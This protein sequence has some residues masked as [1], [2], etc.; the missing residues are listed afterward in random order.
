MKTAS[1]SEIDA[2]RIVDQLYDI[3]LDP[4]TLDTFIGA[5]NDAGLDADAARKTIKSID[6]FDQAYVAH[7]ER[8]DTFL[9][10]G[11]DADKGPDLADIM[12]PFDSLAAFIVDQH[13]VVV[14]S[15]EGAREAFHMTDGIALAAL[16]WP[17]HVMED[18]EENLGDLF[19]NTGR[20]DL[21]L[22]LDTPG[23]RGPALFQIRLLPDAAPSS[24]R[25]A[26][27]VTTQYHWKAALGQ[28]L[29]EVFDLTS[30]EQ[31]VVRALVEGLDAKAIAM[32]RGT[33]EGT[34]R[35]QIKSILSKMNARSQSEVIRL[36]LSLRDVAQPVAGDNAAGRKIPLKRPH[37]DWL[38]SEAYKPLKS[39][40]LPDG[41]KMDYHDMGLANGAPVLFSHMGYGL[42]RWHEP[43]LR[44]AIKNG[45]RVIVPIRA[46]YGKS[47][48]LS[49]DADVLAVCRSDTRH[50][51]E[52]LG[53]AR[54]P[55]VPQ[56]NDL[57]FA[58]D[59]A[60]HHPEMV[61][62]IIGICARPF[63]QGDRH[64]AGMAKW[65]RFFLSTARHAPHLLRFTAKA[66]VALSKRIGPAEMFR[67][68]NQSSVSDMAVL[69]DPEI[70]SILLA[71]AD[72]IAGK[73]TDVSQAYAM[74]LLETEADWSHLIIRAK[75][76]PTSFINGNDDP[77]TDVATIAEYRETY[78][79][80]EVEVI[81][82][83]GQMLIYKH[84]DMVIPKLAEAAKRATASNGEG[85]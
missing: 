40:T 7:L 50:L 53:I 46:G 75:N 4:N 16:P 26:L 8:A 82:D 55:F 81:Q 71:N 33:S 59:M 35:S 12:A 36:V 56:G 2:D 5:W 38:N 66:A 52:H 34:V 9:S 74:E 6:A 39:I 73:D 61:S 15:N 11:S 79:W 72:L 48:P 43:M 10:R 51:L 54:L 83:A 17:I 24:M 21:M 78:P 44:L 28:I 20:T 13:M 80:I 14:A 70:V 60:A 18:L 31:G 41:R 42:A 58:V 23:Q 37:G 27:I 22:R 67:K 3:A 1:S 63:L 64:Y 69:E 77:S 19:A 29:E 32:D 84:F 85:R 30:A 47:D 25:H 65:H 49:F 62:E 68:M 45:L 76:V 57:L